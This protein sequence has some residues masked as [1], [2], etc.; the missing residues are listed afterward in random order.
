M[1]YYFS[2]MQG[3][4]ANRGKHL[5]KTIINGTLHEITIHV[6]KNIDL[7]ANMAQIIIMNKINLV[8]YKIF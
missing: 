5:T 2:S 8:I 6:K 3:V 1:K 7:K 4:L